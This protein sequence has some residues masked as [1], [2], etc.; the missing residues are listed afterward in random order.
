MSSNGH[1]TA[2]DAEVD[3][4]YAWMP[5]A[6]PH[7]ACPEAVFS[8]TMKGCVDGHETLLTVRGQSPAQFKANLAAVRGLLDQPQSGPTPS[9]G[10]LPPCP[11]GHG[12]LRKSTKREGYY[13]PKKNQDGTYCKGRA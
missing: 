9:T 8:L 5:P 11:F 10:E 13:C 6:P 4:L 1:S 12:F 7:T 2:F 3:V